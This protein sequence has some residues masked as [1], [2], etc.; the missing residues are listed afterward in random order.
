MILYPIPDFAFFLSGS[1]I[2]SLKKN[3]MGRNYILDQE[4]VK[5]KLK[6]MAYEIY[7]NNTG[8]EQIT[9]IGI[10]D[11]G[12]VIAEYVQR[13]LNE[14]SPL[15]TKILHLTLD[16]KRP[17]KIQLSDDFSFDDQAVVVVDDVANSGKTMLY[18][19]KPLLE[20][21]PKKI[22]TLALVERT[23]KAFPI[24]TNYVGLSLA[25][26]FQDHIYVEVVNGIIMG[27][28]ID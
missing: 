7:E 27:A 13:L 16:K 19:M 25:T 5:M 17:G 12:S 9:L 24:H 26:T 28:W 10:R 23:H 4:G 6:R 21:H 8:E 18:A 11:N 14:I 15:K 2:L 22:E 1:D 3:Q 20:M